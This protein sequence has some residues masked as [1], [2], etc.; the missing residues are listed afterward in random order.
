MRHLRK[1]IIELVIGTDM[2][3]GGSITKAFANA[4]DIPQEPLEE[5][6]A[7]SDL[8]SL[9]LKANTARDAVLLLQMAMKCSDLGHLAL[10]WDLHVTWVKR[11]EAEF[12]SQGDKE[13]ALGHPVSFLMDREKPGCSHTQVGFFQFVALPLYRSFSHVVPA[14]R[15]MLDAALAN[16]HVW[17]RV[18]G[19]SKSESDASPDTRRS[20]KTSEDAPSFGRSSTKGSDDASCFTEVIER[21]RP[22]SPTRSTETFCRANSKDTS[23]A[24]PTASRQGRRRSGRARQRAAKWWATVRRR[25]PSPDM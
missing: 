18:Q 14:S 3:N 17:E 6:P 11:L 19:A 8:A 2:A 12:F 24:S 16:F 21:G 25:T 22:W 20:S 13:K 15:P 9:E 4:F 23:D 1:L 10:G 7:R 5:Q